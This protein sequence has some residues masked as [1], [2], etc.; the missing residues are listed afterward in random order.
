MNDTERFV[1]IS[2]LKSVFESTPVD[3]IKKSIWDSGHNFSNK[4]H[5]SKFCDEISENIGR[6]QEISDNNINAIHN[7]L[8][9][10][11]PKPKYFKNKENAFQFLSC[12]CEHI[13]VLKMNDKIVDE[14]NDIYESI[15]TKYPDYNPNDVTTWGAN[16]EISDSGHKLFEYILSENK[17]VMSKKDMQML[18]IKKK[19]YEN[20]VP[21]EEG[22][23]DLYTMIY[24]V[25][26]DNSII[27]LY[28]FI[29]GKMV[30][31]SDRIRNDVYDYLKKNPSSPAI[32]MV[33]GEVSGSEMETLR[34]NFHHYDVQS[35]MMDKAFMAFRKNT[36]G[37]MCLI[38]YIGDKKFKVKE[39][40]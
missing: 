12:L 32:D 40:N 4:Y 34:R 29:F 25:L 11:K 7:I 19:I 27:L 20:S 16:S 1:K 15:K 39:I 14:M 36:R 10:L 23:K 8:I 28:S 3:A 26:D 37:K 5:I 22:K 24:S 33:T 9:D 18:Y 35:F 13:N 30:S 38:K 17:M 21:V 2:A 6:L 31:Y